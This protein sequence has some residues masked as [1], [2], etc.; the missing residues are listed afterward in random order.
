M[1]DSVFTPEAL[2]NSTFTGKYFLQ[3]ARLAKL[4]NEKASHLYVYRPNPNDR[5]YRKRSPDPRTHLHSS[6]PQC[7]LVGDLDVDGREILYGLRQDGFEDDDGVGG[8]LDVIGDGYY[9]DGLQ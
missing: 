3:D 7:A 6:A 2:A 4:T 9:G 1:S 8:E 5:T